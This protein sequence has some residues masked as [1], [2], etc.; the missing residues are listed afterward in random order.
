MTH[1]HTLNTP[2]TQRHYKI[3]DFPE[4]LVEFCHIYLLGILEHSAILTS[5]LSILCNNL[6]H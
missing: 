4:T 1:H 3:R 5:D 6:N 2:F